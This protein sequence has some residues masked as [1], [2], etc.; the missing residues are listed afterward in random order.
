MNTHSFTMQVTI[1]ERIRYAEQQ[2]KNY[3]LLPADRRQW[4][5]EARNLR[6]QRRAE[7]AGRN[8]MHRLYHLGRAVGRAEL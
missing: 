5:V 4:K 8:L 1:E 7:N 6:V 3:Y 2:A